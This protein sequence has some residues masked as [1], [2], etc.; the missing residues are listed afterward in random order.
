LKVCVTGGTGFVGGALVRRLLDEKIS[1]RVL[2]RPSSRADELERRGA[3]MIRGHLDD[4]DSVKSVVSG[5][6]CV[7]HVAAMVEAAGD[8]ADFIDANLGGT[9]RVFNACLE[10]GVRQV[11]YTSSIAVYGPVDEGTVI[12]ENTPYDSAPERRDSYSRSKI[13]A[14]EFA[15]GFAQKNTLPLAILRPGIVFGPGKALPIGLL[16]FRVGKSNIIFADRKN[17]F[18]LNYI[19]NL[20]DVILLAG[21]RS[22]FGLRHYIVLDDDDLTLAQYYAVRAALDGTRAIFLPG[23]PVLAAAALAEPAMRLLHLGSGSG[24]TLHQARR[25]LQDRHYDTR[26][27]RRELGWAPRIPLCEALRRSTAS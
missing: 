11:V 1:V 23:G 8:T 26:R 12:D 22:E 15:V 21:N 9:M 17:R 6:D 5:T 7:Y 4:P 13:L 16:G 20:V 14:D 2:A 24:F 19:E 25:S 18:P 3:E 27:I 10:S